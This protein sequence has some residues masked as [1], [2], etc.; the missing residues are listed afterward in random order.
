MLRGAR[1]NA[2]AVVS[3]LPPATAEAALLWW[4]PR[5]REPQPGFT[6][7]LVA[8]DDARMHEEVVLPPV[9]VVRVEVP[10][11]VPAAAPVAVESEP[12]EAAEIVSAPREFRV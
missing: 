3:E 11:G 5:A 6:M 4:V 12:L 9:R 2:G 8:G 10:A 1:L 7:R